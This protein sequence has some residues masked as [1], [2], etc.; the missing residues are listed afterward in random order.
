MGSLGALCS[1]FKDKTGS[2]YQKCLWSFW[3]F[4]LVFLVFFFGPLVILIF[5]SGSFCLY[6]TRIRKMGKGNSFTLCVSPH[7]GGG[8]GTDGMPLAFT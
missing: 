1:G 8:G 2:E 6:T 4:P 5:S 7:L 3:S